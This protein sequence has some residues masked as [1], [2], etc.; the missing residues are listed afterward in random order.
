MRPLMGGDASRAV[1]STATPRRV[2]GASYGASSLSKS[3]VIYRKPQ[4]GSA[5]VSART[6]T[7]TRISPDFPHRLQAAY[8]SG[9]RTFESCRAHH[10]SNYLRV[11]RLRL[12]LASGTVVALR[13]VR[14]AGA[15]I[16]AAHTDIG[17]ALREIGTGAVIEARAKGCTRSAK[18]RLAPALSSVRLRPS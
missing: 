18:C 16:A 7:E 5:D 13:P 6:R 11:P 3:T 17:L 8:E 1:A 10:V 4:N 14:L 12:D 2:A 9:G 15:K